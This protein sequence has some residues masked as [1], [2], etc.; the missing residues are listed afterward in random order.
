MKFSRPEYWSG[1]HWLLPGIFPNPGIEPRSATLQAESCS[2]LS[3]SPAEPPGQHLDKT[4]VLGRERRRS[5]ELDWEFGVGRFK[6]LIHS[7][8]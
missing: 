4:L 8:D 7:V 5:G 3:S 2:E 6:L 1:S